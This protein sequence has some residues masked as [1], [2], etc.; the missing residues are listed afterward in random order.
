[1]AGVAPEGT[2][3]LGPSMLS[4]GAERWTA[5]VQLERRLNGGGSRAELCPAPPPRP[6]G[7]HAGW[8]WQWQWRDE[9]L[10]MAAMVCAQRAAV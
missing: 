8:Q 6:G 9:L 1:M 3:A 5:F 2:T 4:R 10:A 7:A